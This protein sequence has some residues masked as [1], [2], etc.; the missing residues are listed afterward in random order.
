MSAPSGDIGLIKRLWPFVQ[1]WKKWLVLSLLLTPIGVGAG[2][3]QPLILKTGI[4][5]FIAAGQLEGLGW[6]SAAFL[7]VVAVAF[8]ARA[9]GAFALQR[10]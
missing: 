7:A 1:P 3:V 9:L 5:D 10:V 2:L 4:D 6:L 8:G